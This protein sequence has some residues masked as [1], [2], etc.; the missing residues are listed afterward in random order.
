[1]CIRDRDETACR[2]ST[3]SGDEPVVCITGVSRAHCA[4]LGTPVDR[5]TDDP[6]SAFVAL[7][8]DRCEPDDCVLDA[9]NPDSQTACAGLSVQQ[10]RTDSGNNRLSVS[11]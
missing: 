8:V 1:M 10:A 11:D 9:K 3:E 2:L 7:A 5:F 6:S 4:S